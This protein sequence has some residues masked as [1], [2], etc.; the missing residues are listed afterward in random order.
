M[1]RG[2]VGLRI[3][4]ERNTANEGKVHFEDRYLSPLRTGATGPAPLRDNL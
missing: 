2:C 1:I 4:G 3:D